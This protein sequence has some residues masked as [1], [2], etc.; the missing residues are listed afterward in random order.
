[1]SD[2][3]VAAFE[4]SQFFK[5]AVLLR[6]WD[7]GAKVA[8]WGVPELDEYRDDVVACLNDG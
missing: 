8:G 3:E 5:T 7:D 4:G 1:M 2:T 6:G